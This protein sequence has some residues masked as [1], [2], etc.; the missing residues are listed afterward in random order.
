LR[1][2]EEKNRPGYVL[3]AVLIVIVV[4]SLA[5]Y[6]FTDLMTAQYRSEVRA[7]DAV[8]ARHAAVSG[9]HYA[10]ALLA[11]PASFYGDLGGNPYIEG[12]FSDQVVRQND[13]QRLEAR[14][15]L[16]AVA[17]TGQGTFEQ[18]YGAV[19]DEAGKLNINSLIQ[20]DPSGELLYSALMMFS[21]VNPNMT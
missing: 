14:F 16:V 11:D 8:Q 9:I 5:A 10:A 21:S 12:A 17:N 1:G 3:I 13:N 19:I 6:Q 4:L 7:G 20:L 18:R 15:A 2:K